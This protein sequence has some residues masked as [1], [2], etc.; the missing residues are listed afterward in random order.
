MCQ[1]CGV[2]YSASELQLQ[3]GAEG[4]RELYARAKQAYRSKN[5][6]TARRLYCQLAEDDDQQAAFYAR[7][8]ACQL[9]PGGETDTLLKQLRLALMQGRAAGPEAYFDFASRALGEVIVFALS[10]E[11]SYEEA[12]QSRAQRLEI[13][14]RLTLQKAHQEM[15]QGAG[16][17]WL[18]MSRAAHLCVGG[19]D[20]LSAASSYFWELI[21]AIIDD[22]SINQKRGTIALGN[23][24]E[25]R[26]YFESLKEEKQ[27]KKLVNG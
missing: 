11:E 22:L 5:F 23:V 9:N 1:A 26:A 21:E 7:L 3:L 27:A 18:L 2:A 14:S 10:V 20:D 19:I 24:A 16:Q 8:S 15:Q 4:R 17:A 6:Q 13:S 12:F 25:E